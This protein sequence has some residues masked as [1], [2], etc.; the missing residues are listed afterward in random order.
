[1]LVMMSI[2]LF[3]MGFY[4]YTEAFVMDFQSEFDQIDK[5]LHTPIEIKRHFVHLIQFHEQISTYALDKLILHI[6]MLY[7]FYI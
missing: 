6:D 4:Y 5:S 3:F 1:M 2:M 7:T